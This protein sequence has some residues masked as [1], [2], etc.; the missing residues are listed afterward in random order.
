MPFSIRRRDDGGYN[1][2]RRNNSLSEI[3]PDSF[4]LLGQFLPS[5]RKSWRE[6]KLR[7]RLGGRFMDEWRM[8]RRWKLDEVT[9]FE[10]VRILDPEPDTRGNE[11]AEGELAALFPAFAGMKIVES[12]AGLMDVTPDV[13][14]VIGPVDAL[15]GFFIATGFSGHGFGIGPGAG[16]LM[17]DLVAGDTPV[18]DPAPFRFGRFADGSFRQYI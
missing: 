1:I 9:P 18:V 4:R 3:T 12:W 10:Q 13:V 11:R 2:A 6:V 7:L 16:R 8:P 14:P 17:A 15:P 5:Y